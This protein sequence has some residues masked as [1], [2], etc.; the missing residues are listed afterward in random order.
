[1]VFDC[2]GV[3]LNSNRIKTQAFYK[4]ALPYGEEVARALVEYHIQH[5]GISRYHKFEYFL[6]HIVPGESNGP[7][8]EDLLDTY[9]NEVRDGLLECEI[10]EEI[11]EL[12]LMSSNEKWLVVSGGDQLE[13]RDVFKTRGLESRFDGGIFGSPKSKFDIIAHELM[14]GNILKP[15]LM[16]GDSKLDHDVASFFGLDFVF[17]SDWTEF[18]EWQ[19]FVLDNKVQSF[20]SV[21]NALIAYR[22]LND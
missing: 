21:K 5:G 14:A 22:S 8:F 4:A 9:A 6:T 17:V 10:A 11:S 3:L 20:T 2:D 7:S 13:L 16:L 1:M 12:R 15:A 18:R 19:T